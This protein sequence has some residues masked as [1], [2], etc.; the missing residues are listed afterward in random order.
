[1]ERFCVTFHAS[2]SVGRQFF[3]IIGV[4]EFLKVLFRSNKMYVL[5]GI[6]FFV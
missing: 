5:K 3:R 6:I 4:E 2:N 1:M